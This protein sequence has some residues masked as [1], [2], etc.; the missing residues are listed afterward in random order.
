MKVKFDY[1]KQLFEIEEIIGKM[2]DLI[3]K[4]EKATLRKIG[5][6]VQKYVTRQLRLVR[7]TAKEIESRKNYDKT[8]PYIQMDDD[9]KVAVKKSRTGD[10]YASI[11]GGKYTGYKWHM[12]N[13]GTRNLDGSVHT[14][15]THFMDLALEQSK[16]EVDKIISDLMKKVANDG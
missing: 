5:K 4:E 6:A 8:V 2:P 1:E 16:A 11:K 9:V 15:A 10:I 14:P 7:M 13:D 12:L 3:Q